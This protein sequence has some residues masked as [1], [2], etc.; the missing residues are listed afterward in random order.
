MDKEIGLTSLADIEAGLERLMPR[1]LTD[2]ARE[3]L[4][5]VVDDLAAGASIIPIWKRTRVWQSAA[6]A[7]LIVGVG[8]A[9]VMRQSPLAEGIPAL[10]QLASSEV[11]SGIAVLEQVSWIEGG[12]DLGVQS[13]NEEGDV[14]QGWSYVGVEEESV[15]HVSSGY[16]VILQREFGAELYSPSSL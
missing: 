15:L 8:S 10:A 13:I 9:L 5:G 6:A 1:G 2:S 4:E 3:D 12:A 14:S 7:L 11:D 16:K